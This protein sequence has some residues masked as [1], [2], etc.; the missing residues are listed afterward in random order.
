M[1][2]FDYSF[3]RNIKVPVNF[4]TFTNAIYTLKNLEEE[5]KNIYPDIFTALQKIA[6]VQSV[7][8]SNEIE[9]IVTTDKRIE[10]IVN[11]SSAPLNHNEQEI[12]GY[13]NALNLIHSDSDKMSLNEDLI[14]NLHKILLEKIEV[15]YGGSYK[16]EDNIIRESYKDGTSFVRWVL[17]SSQ[18]TPKAMKELI[19]A[20]M[21]ARDDSLIDGLLLIPCVILDFLC[22]HPFRDGNGRISR[23][24]TLFLLYKSGF[25][26]SKYISFE[27]QINKMKG[28]YYEALKRSSIGWHDNQNDYIP[29]IEN[30]LYTLYLCYKELDKR[31]LTLG[32]KKVSKKKRIESAIMNSFLPISKK[33]LQAL[34]PDISLTTIE[35]VLA[36]MLND[37][38][39]K[40][41]GSTKSA[42]YIK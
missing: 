21:E 19:L 32:T 8:G 29:F 26:I 27:E 17:V 40:K 1:R 9:G 22:I 3:L 10:E 6:I 14:L 4:M 11:Q 42:K 20:Y 23:L 2:R 5:K 39:I 7:K 24:L 37:G 12:L 36:S 38:K 13:K 30:F 41:I 33:E 34:L 18:D 15:S 25:D 16:T 28:N 35:A 31:F